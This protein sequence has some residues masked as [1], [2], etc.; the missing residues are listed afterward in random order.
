MDRQGPGDPPSRR[1]PPDADGRDQQGGEAPAASSAPA[2]RAMSSPVQLQK[3]S[4]GKDQKAA[5]PRPASSTPADSTPLRTTASPNAS[6]VSPVHR[7][8]QR[9]RE[10]AS[11]VVEKASPSEHKSPEC[12]AFDPSFGWVRL[13]DSKDSSCVDAL[14]VSGSGDEATSKTLLLDGSFRASAEPAEPPG[15]RPRGEPARKGSSALPSKTREGKPGEPRATSSSDG[16]EQ[17]GASCTLKSDDERPETHLLHNVSSRVGT[18]LGRIFG[19]SPSGRAAQPEAV[20][21]EVGARTGEASRKRKPHSYASRQTGDTEVVTEVRPRTKESLLQPVAHSYTKTMSTRDV[22]AE[23]VGACEERLSKSQE[24][25]TEG[26]AADEEKRDREAMLEIPATESSLTG[27]P[28]PDGHGDVQ[29]KRTRLPT[30]IVRGSAAASPHRYTVAVMTA[31]GESPKRRGHSENSKARKHRK[32]RQPGDGDAKARKS[33]SSSSGRGK[34]HGR[35]QGRRR[36]KESSARSS[37]ERKKSKHDDKTEDAADVLE[38]QT[39]K[40][41]TYD[42][43]DKLAS[44]EFSFEIALQPFTRGALPRPELTRPSEQRLGSMRES[45]VSPMSPH[46]VEPGSPVSPERKASPPHEDDLGPLI[47]HEA[48][49]DHKARS[50][51]GRGKKPS[52]KDDLSPPVETSASPSPADETKKPRK[53]RSDRKSRSERRHRSKS[54]H[55]SKRA[56]SGKAKPSRGGEPHEKEVS[57]PPKEVGASSPA[58]ESNSREETSHR[59]SRSK[60]SHKSKSKSKHGSKHSS[61]HGR[62]GRSHSSPESG[63]RSSRE[64]RKS[65]GTHGRKKYSPKGAPGRS[66]TGPYVFQWGT[67][68]IPGV[69]GVELKWSTRHIHLDSGGLLSPG[70]DYE[71]DK[72]APDWIPFTHARKPSQATGTDKKH[73]EVVSSNT[74]SPT[75]TASDLSGSGKH[76]DRGEGSRRSPRRKR[77]ERGPSSSGRRRG[78]S[79]DGHRGRG[80]SGDR[81]SRRKHRP[82]HGKRKGRKHR[83]KRER[84]K[85]PASP[86][87]PAS[88]LGATSPASPSGAAS[89]P[90]VSSPPMETP[91]PSPEPTPDAKGEKDSPRA[92]SRSRRKGKEREKGSSKRSLSSRRSKKKSMSKSRKSRSPKSE[93]DSRSPKLG[94]DAS[95]ESRK[96]RKRKKSRGSGKGKRSRGGQ[97][98]GRSEKARESPDQKSPD[99]TP[100][101]E[102]RSGSRASKRSRSKR[103]KSRKGRGKKRRKGK[104]GSVSSRKSRRSAKSPD[105]SGSPDVKDAA[106]IQKGSREI[107]SPEQR[108]ETRASKRS[109]SSRR[110]GRRSRS[111]H[112]SK[113]R[114]R[115]GK[116]SGSRSSR[117]SK[118]SR[119][120][121]R[122]RGR[123]SRS[124]RRPKRHRGK[125]SDKRSG[126]RKKSRSS[127]SRSRS[128][129]SHGKKKRRSRRGKSGRRHRISRKK[130]RSTRAS[131][132]R[133]LHDGKKST[134][135]V[136]Y[137]GERI[138]IT[139]SLLIAAVIATLVLLTCVLAL[140]YIVVCRGKPGAST[141]ISQST[142]SKVKRR[143]TRSPRPS[144]E[145]LEPY[146]CTTDYCRLEAE[147]IKALRSTTSSPCDDFY[148]HVCAAWVS[149]HPA[150]STSTGS[151]ISQDTLLQVAL[152]RRVLDQL[153]S[154]KSPADVGV[155]AGLHSDCVDRIVSIPPAAESLRSL[156]AKWSIA[157]WPRGDSVQGGEVAVWRFAAELARDLG[158][159]TIARVGVSVNPDDLDETVVELDVPRFLLA[160]AGQAAGNPAVLFKQ[161]VGEVV[162][163]LKASVPGDFGDRLFAVRSGFAALKR[164]RYDDEDARVVRF[165]NL[166]EGLREFVT[167]LLANVPT[168][169]RGETSVVLRSAPYF[170]RDVGSVLRSA[171]PANTLNYFG[172]LVIVHAAPFLSHDMRS[173]RN[174]FTD[175][176]LGRT[177]GNA[178]TDTPLLC[179]WL[180]DQALPD[181]VAKAASLWLHSAGRDVVTRE[182]LSQLEA[183][184]LRH[185]TDLPWISELSA[186]LV[187]YRLKR[188]ATTQ[189]G[190]A[191]SKRLDC[192]RGVSL[193]GPNPLLVFWNVSKQRQDKVLRGLLMRGDQLRAR[194]WAG[195]S[196]LSAEASFRRDLQLVHVPAALFNDSVPP[197][198]SVFVFHLARVAVRFYRA[199]AQFLHENPYER[200]AP[201]SIANDYDYDY[202]YR[203][204]EALE[205]LKKHGYAGDPRG[206]QRSAR[207][208]LDRMTA[209]ILAVTAFDQLLPIRRIW[210]LDLRFK[211]LPDVTAQQ[212]FFIYFALDNCE[213]ADP[214]YHSGGLSAKQRVNV[215]LKHLGRFAAAFQC[216]RGAPMAATD[217]MLD[218][219]RRRRL[220]AQAAWNGR[221]GVAMETP[222]PP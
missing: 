146:Y 156:F 75:E 38:T 188:Q 191:P 199:L 9:Q 44:R 213:S 220:V 76:G 102:K 178:V 147:Y 79:K 49:E 210:R 141:I 110:S 115:G 171:P 182:W 6:S 149:Q 214:A 157:S 90:S 198:S 136:G 53:T 148:D 197:T 160:D 1:R 142:T 34:K 167:V 96:S 29:V 112:K 128:R 175:S 219:G 162:R 140:Y 179:A 39:G 23:S 45:P 25:V 181:C 161:A 88:P 60:R 42:V 54:K 74:P 84:G 4:A 109:K 201:L 194:A 209:L 46:S 17:L 87:S 211:D 180:V 68:D 28:F 100:S 114:S 123:H 48:R 11:Q 119:R 145:S 86:Q 67:A 56:H 36:D 105:I 50:R 78:K 65:H 189:V 107:V 118:S 170:L 64:H 13:E 176:V 200:D 77:G 195:R 129:S 166:S 24:G 208:L 97:S 111:K 106:K 43:S 66:G 26:V 41:S 2:S 184:F 207:A 155:A 51:R 154:A 103:S 22:A 185:V 125:R 104:S 177:V 139:Y 32:G 10:R 202:D 14:R 169:V 137:A 165:R 192:A 71:A 62:K 61:K 69:A 150:L 83:S 127:R 52:A 163:E 30:G 73:S 215:P 193:V 21:P 205:C 183:V 15:K 217:C 99:S 131:R 33:R 124:S 18:L 130:S 81:R 173:L 113:S 152:T 19:R 89:P 204:A 47:K 222:A 63:E 7:Q 16:G 72:H 143:T 133:R 37:R 35:K 206:A 212:L 135:Q 218:Q 94:S 159:A 101:P 126:S 221:E 151:L 216:Q 164:S 57:S 187:R 5:S 138:S 132:A 122:K 98:I 108:S 58:P 95:S 55:G 116:K 20:G 158:L 203:L 186:L 70:G 144:T 117:K 168:P 82:H 174:L 172:F 27:V 80:K 93:R 3:K 59:K 190:P 85:G 120:S 91:S 121:R 153:K 31:A 134:E 8:L 40:G 196:E 92:Q 12:F